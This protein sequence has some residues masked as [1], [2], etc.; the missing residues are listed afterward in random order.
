MVFCDPLGRY[1][2]Y[3]KKLIIATVFIKKKKK[4][5]VVCSL[6]WCVDFLCTSHALNGLLTELCS[7]V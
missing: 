2:P 5:T 6:F 1:I 7:V 4:E 3:K